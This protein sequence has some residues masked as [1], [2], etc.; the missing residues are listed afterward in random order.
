MEI[1]STF[2]H[3]TI[4]QDLIDAINLLTH[5][6]LVPRARLEL[7]CLAAR[8]FKSLVSTYFTIW[9]LYNFKNY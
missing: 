9:G 1:I 2:F 8:D 5:V 4:F 7:A 6:H 3:P